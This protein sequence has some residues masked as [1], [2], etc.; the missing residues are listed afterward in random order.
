MDYYKL[1]PISVTR[2]VNG[3]TN[4]YHGRWFRDENES[5]ILQVS[6][7]NSLDMGPVAVEDSAAAAETLFELFFTQREAGRPGPS[8]TTE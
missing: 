4:T 5:I 6:G 1:T 8:G 2:E 3:V 7:Q